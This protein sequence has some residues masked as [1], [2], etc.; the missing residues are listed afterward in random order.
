MQLH[1]RIAIYIIYAVITM[2]C[3]ALVLS[4]RA[5]LRSACLFPCVATVADMA[6]AEELKLNSEFDAEYPGTAVIRM[7][8]ARARVRQLSAGAL[9]GDWETVRQ[10]LLWAGGMRDLRSARPGAGYTGHSFNDFN[11]CDLTCMLGSVQGES[12]TDGAVVGISSSNALGEGIRVASIPELG[13]GGSWSTC[14]IGCAEDP[15]RDVAHSAVQPPEAT[16]QH[17]LS[18]RS[19]TPPDQTQ[20]SEPLSLPTHFC[21]LPLVL[22]PL[23]AADLP[24]LQVP[25]LAPMCK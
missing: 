18:P 1:E 3:A 4:R 5:A 13:V 24:T 12:N 23:D 22:D 10:R 2:P 25:A 8:A 14:M 16:E 11:H 19:C 21:C 6:R 17:A 15:P 7:N 20:A 9:D